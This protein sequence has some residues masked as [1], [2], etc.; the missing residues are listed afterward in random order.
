MIA[1]GSTKSIVHF[2]QLKSQR[3]TKTV[4]KHVRGSEWFFYY[5][6]SILFVVDDISHSYV[7]SADYLDR[8]RAIYMRF[9]F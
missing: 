7:E 5:L 3:G 6:R 4:E 9:T 1:S 8:I 2:N